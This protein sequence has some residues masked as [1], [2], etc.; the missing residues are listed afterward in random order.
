[1]G[2]AFCMLLPDSLFRTSH[3]QARLCEGMRNRFK[4]FSRGILVHGAWVVDQ[5][6]I[7]RLRILN[8]D[9]GT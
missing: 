8:P 4:S 7:L 1:M 5:I 9:P 2:M 3:F 6:L